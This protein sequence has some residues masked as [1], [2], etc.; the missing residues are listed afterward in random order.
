MTDDTSPHGFAGLDGTLLAKIGTAA[1]VAAA[2]G[3]TSGQKAIDKATQAVQT[4]ENHNAN[5][6]SPLISLTQ[7]GEPIAEAF[8]RKHGP[9]AFADFLHFAVGLIAPLDPTTDPTHN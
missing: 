2:T 4:F 1:L 5:I 9:A 7:T 8:I 6:M 3:S